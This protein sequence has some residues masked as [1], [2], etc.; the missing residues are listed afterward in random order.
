MG[1]TLLFIIGLLVG[2]GIMWIIRRGNKQQLRDQIRAEVIGQIQAEQATL[3]ERLQAR[4]TQLQDMKNA[5]AQK[6]SQIATFEATNR[7]LLLTYKEQ[8]AQL[9]A[10]LSMVRE[11]LSGY[12]VQLQKTGEQLKE[13]DTLITTLQEE[14]F[15]LA[16]QM[17]E[18]ETRLQE[19]RKS[20]QEKLVFLQ[21]MEQR[22]TGAFKALSADALSMNN[23]SF[24]TLAQESLER[25]QQN[26]RT[27]LEQR[28]EAINNLVMPVQQTLKSFEQ[29]VQEIERERVGSYAALIE[30]VGHLRTTQESLRTE[31]S[32]LVKALRAPT[33]RGRWGEIQ[34]KR[35]VEMA[36]MLD[37]CD[38]R[39]QE[40]VVTDE[41]TLRPDLTIYLP[42]QKTIV[43]DAKAP[44]EAYLDALDTEDE[45]QRKLK[46]QAH[47]RQIRNHIAILGKKSYW[48]QFQSSPEFVVLFLP[49][50]VFFSAAL[51]HDPSLI[52]VGVE[53]RVI[54][55]TPT[56]LIAL[57]RAVS[58]GWTQ[59]NLARNAQE[60]AQAGRELYERLVKMNEHW[61]KVGKSLSGAVESYNQAT[62]SLES[63]VMV[64]A[65]KLGELR[66]VAVTETIDELV[67]I[68]RNPRE[69]QL[70]EK[71]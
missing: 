54:L 14:K 26:A 55:A 60:I 11:R 40:S 39:E 53:E 50:E 12:E 6:D 70:T 1:Y 23:Q 56:T 3:T 28:Q 49:G 41:K 33:V 66:S 71:N 36:G 34:L 45:D 22:F 18:L 67:V 21:E 32:N 13:K 46:L 37:H 44:L 19:E 43:V 8:E 16:T 29:K 62:G 17:S 10:E 30:Q 47:A 35:V 65:R 2:M 5:L 27:D 51:E 15:A 7:S 4:E 58:Y 48:S 42:G 59:E 25:F 57:L 38:F 68:D 52:E 61:R 9:N 24:L 69:L 64:S 31:T 63:R 20:M